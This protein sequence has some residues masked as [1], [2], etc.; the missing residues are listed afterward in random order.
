MH[1]GL[2]EPHIFLVSSNPQVLM[3]NLRGV[4]TTPQLRKI[5]AE[6]DSNVVGL[7]QLGDKHFTFAKGLSNANWRQKISRYYYGAYNVRR[8]LALNHSGAFS[9][10]SSDHKSV[11]Q[12]PDSLP[13]NGAHKQML[14]N[15][16]DDRN[17]CDY[18][19]MARETDLLVPLPNV[20]ALVTLFIN[21]IRSYLNT[22]GV[23]V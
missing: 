12:I 1:K 13:N 10:D 17:L 22:N 21:D 19:H 8:A 3:R 7:F 9:T 6:V 11:D 4:L 2:N 15:L 20:E 23:A 5:Q 16:R 18:S 14:K